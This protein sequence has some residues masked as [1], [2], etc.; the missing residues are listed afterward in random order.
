M[1]KKQ[2]LTVDNN[3]TREMLQQTADTARYRFA[4]RILARK[5]VYLRE[6]SAENNARLL[7]RE[8]KVEAPYEVEV[9]Q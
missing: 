9:V 6:V 8:P 4:R 2:R 1:P 7:P 5:D 3:G